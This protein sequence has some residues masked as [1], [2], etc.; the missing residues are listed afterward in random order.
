[1]YSCSLAKGG[2]KSTNALRTLYGT[3][4]IT[5]RALDG[6]AVVSDIVTSRDPRA[7]SR[8]L[9]EIIQ[10]FK[11]TRATLG[12]SMLAREGRFYRMDSILNAVGNILGT[13]RKLSPL[14]HQVHLDCIAS[15]LS[16]TYEKS[17][18]K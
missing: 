5:G 14:V 7:A 6:I 4:S 12:D 1:M 16:R 9:A 18:F 10:M 2:I 17:P 11:R 3:V 13:V 8:S 15:L